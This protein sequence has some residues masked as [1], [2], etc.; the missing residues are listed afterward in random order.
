MIALVAPLVIS[1]VLL[2]RLHITN[3]RWRARRSPPTRFHRGRSRAD[4]VRTRAFRPPPVDTRRPGSVV[5]GPPACARAPASRRRLMP[6]AGRPVLSRA[7]D[8]EVHAGRGRGDRR[9][10][11]WD[12]EF[13]AADRAPTVPARGF[14]V[15]ALGEGPPARRPDRRG[16]A[17][18][19]ALADSRRPA[20][21]YDPAPSTTS[22]LRAWCTSST[23]CTSSTETR[24]QELSSRLPSAYAQTSSS[25]SCSASA[26]SRRLPHVAFVRRRGQVLDL[27]APRPSLHRGQGSRRTSPLASTRAPTRSPTSSTWSRAGR[28]RRSTRVRGSVRSTDA[29]SPRARSRVARRPPRAAVPRPSRTKSSGASQRR[30]QGLLRVLAELGGWRTPELLEALGRAGA[31]DVLVERQG[32]AGSVRRPAAGRGPQLSLRRA[33]CTSTSRSELGLEPLSH[34]DLHRGV[35][36]MVRVKGATAEALPAARSS[37]A[38]ARPWHDCLKLH[39]PELNKLG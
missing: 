17:D 33:W 30:V 9:R 36:R 19:T 14:S 11:A 10:S 8:R 22:S 1:S 15:G 18:Q 13:D 20:G 35:S 31:A 26:T 5:V 34:R 21:V 29:E 3:R 25:I 12:H 16:S 28:R 6:L 4:P 32:G 24:A 7:G 2:V 37:R 39:A 27:G 38:T 23:T